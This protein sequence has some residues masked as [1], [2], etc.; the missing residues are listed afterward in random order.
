[1]DRGLW[2][3][4]RYTRM[5]STKPN[6]A[7]APDSVWSWSRSGGDILRAVRLG[8][9]PINQAGDLRGSP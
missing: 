4:T 1:M 8:C 6:R 3:L 5:R 7:A 2:Q 9:W